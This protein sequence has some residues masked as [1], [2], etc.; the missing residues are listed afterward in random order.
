MN[1]KEKMRGFTLLELLIAITLFAVI[2]TICYRLL[3]TAIRSKELTTVVWEHLNEIQKAKAI[4]QKDVNQI[5]GRPVRI[6]QYKQQYAMESGRRE[7][8]YKNLITFTRSGWLNFLDQPRSDLQRV[9]YALEDD[10]LVRYYWPVL[11]PSSNTEFYKQVL[12]TGISSADVYFLDQKKRWT[13]QWP[14]ISEEQKKRIKLLPAAIRLTVTH[15]YYGAITW[16]FTGVGEPPMKSK[17]TSAVDS[18]NL[19]DTGNKNNTGLNSNP[20]V[21]KG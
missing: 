3:D 11:D 14:P 7:K 1:F 2:A 15:H 8:D 10:K 20:R 12:L 21:D 6:D 18:N 13:K 5:I 19:K 16:L 4:L 9:S 17:G